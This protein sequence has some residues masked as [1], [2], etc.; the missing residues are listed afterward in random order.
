[1]PQGARASRPR[2]TGTNKGLDGLLWVPL[3]DSPYSDVRGGG[4]SDALRRGIC[5]ELY[6]EIVITQTLLRTSTISSVL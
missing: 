6:A 5:L 1:M 4:V 3:S 2:N